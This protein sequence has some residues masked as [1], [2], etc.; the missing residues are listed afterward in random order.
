[1]R[2]IAA[3]LQEIC[4]AAPSEGGAA[5]LLFLQIFASP[6]WQQMDIFSKRMGVGNV[7]MHNFAELRKS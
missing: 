4:W 1:M 7:F 6:V 2:K 3:Y 5:Q